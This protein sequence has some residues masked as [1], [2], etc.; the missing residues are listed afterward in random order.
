MGREGF[1]KL[2]LI[3][4]PLKLVVDNRVTTSVLHGADAVPSDSHGFGK[5]LCGISSS[6]IHEGR[7]RVSNNHG[8]L[9]ESTEAHP[10]LCAYPEALIGPAREYRVPSECE[11]IFQVDRRH[12]QRL[13][14]LLYLIVPLQLIVCHWIPP[15][16]RIRGDA[17]PF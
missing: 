4:G 6:Y 9:R 11:L 15:S 10:I 3:V 13:P 1:P 8:L 5:D 12:C 17:F 14:L 7:D 2:S 16:L